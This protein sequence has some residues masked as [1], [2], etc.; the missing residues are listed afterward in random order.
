M[1]T[2]KNHKKC[3]HD[4]STAEWGP[5]HLQR[6]NEYTNN[7]EIYE[8]KHFLMLAKLQCVFAVRAVA[9]V[10]S[11]IS[12]WQTTPGPLSFYLTDLRDAECVHLLSAEFAY[13]LCGG[14]LQNRFFILILNLKLCEYSSLMQKSNKHKKIN[15]KKASTPGNESLKFISSNQRVMFFVLCSAN[16]MHTSN[17]YCVCISMYA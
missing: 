3:L 12:R 13:R 8:G 16:V 9:I 10:W 11:D 1:H 17:N 2:V 7:E 14:I 6:S 4:Q 15:L 5:K